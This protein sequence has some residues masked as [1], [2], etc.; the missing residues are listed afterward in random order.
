[1]TLTKDHIMTNSYDSTGRRS[2]N[3]GKLEVSM[4][5]SMLMSTC[6]AA[7]LLHIW[8]EKKRKNNNTGLWH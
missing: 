1:M 6:S 7:H 4:S 2:V 3:V 5:V 8:T